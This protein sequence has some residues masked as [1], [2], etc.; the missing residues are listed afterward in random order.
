MDRNAAL[1]AIP[2]EVVHAV[3]SAYAE[4]LAA[5]EQRAAPNGLLY[6]YCDANALLS[7]FH[8]RQVWATDT[9]YL[10]DSTELVSLFDGVDYHLK[11]VSTDTEKYVR[12]R[13]LIITKFAP[14]FRANL[15]GLSSYVSCFS[16]DGDVL[17]Q[18]RAYGANGM[19]FAIGF[20]PKE[21]R[22]LEKGGGG[23]LKRMIYGGNKEEQI[24]L[25][26]FNKI[27]AALSSL[28][29]GFDKYGF[30][31]MDLEEW[32]RLRMSEFLHEVAFEC[33][34]PAF[35]EER[36][37]RI[38]GGTGDLRFRASN[39]RIVPYKLLDIS[40]VDDASKAPIKEIVIGPCANPMESE[41]ALT[42]LADTLG[43]GHAGIKF[44]RSQ[45]PYRH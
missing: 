29:P 42:Y 44:R 26:Y 19:G 1:Q 18:W 32:L 20:E 35:H 5:I 43:Y 28:T 9:G 31:T 6:H 24:V 23:T 27:V 36:E 30:P 41:R 39:N 3:L 15:I 34:H 21:L 12:D 45:A 10:N 38:L 16:E 14:K 4:G 2:T 17:S 25:D 33:K 22:V 8:N 40:S 37:W 13:M 11:S 7:I